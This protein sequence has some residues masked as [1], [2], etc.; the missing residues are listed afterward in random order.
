MISFQAAQSLC[1]DLQEVITYLPAQNIST[2]LCQELAQQAKQFAQFNEQLRKVHRETTLGLSTKSEQLGMVNTT[3]TLLRLTAISKSIR[4]TACKLKNTLQVDADNMSSEQGFFTAEQLMKTADGISLLATART[5]E[6]P[7]ETF[8]Q[9]PAEDKD[10]IRSAFQYAHRVIDEARQDQATNSRLSAYEAILQVFAKH[11]AEFL[12]QERDRSL[13]ARCLESQAE[14]IRKFAKSLDSRIEFLL[15]EFKVNFRSR[16]YNAAQLSSPIQQIG[17]RSQI[18]QLTPLLQSA[19][20]G[21]AAE[22][23]GTAELALAFG[24]TLL[25]NT[26]LSLTGKPLYDKPAPANNTG[27]DKNTPPAPDQSQLDDLCQTLLNTA[28]DLANNNRDKETGKDPKITN[29]G[30]TN[31]AAKSDET[32]A[33]KPPGGEVDNLNDSTDEK[34]EQES[35]D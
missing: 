13:H 1:A 5:A 21:K 9:I 23:K 8:Q 19:L 6:D 18:L 27:T 25:E 4:S 14:M 22:L 12:Y 16:L 7:L 35:T 24:P 2:K 29:A 20:G 33:D 11:S 28:F 26:C 17:L 15:T 3:A 34:P 10:K 30:E 32:S 31:K